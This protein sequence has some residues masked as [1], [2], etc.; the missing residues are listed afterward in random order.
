MKK[1]LNALA[2]LAAITSLG[3][4]GALP[5]GAAGRGLPPTLA[6][7]SAAQVASLSLANAKKWGSCT[8]VSRGTAVGFTFGS[9]TDSGSREAR[10][11]VIFNGYHGQVLFLSGALYM[12]ESAALLRVQFGKSDPRDAN[13]WILLPPGNKSYRSVSNGLLFSSMFTQVRPGGVLHESKVGTL[14]G[15]KVVAVTGQANPELGLMR[16]VETLFV[17]AASPYLPVKLIA[18]GRSQGVPTSLSV[19]FSHWG[20]HFRITAPRGALTL[21][22]N[23][24]P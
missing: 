5:A 23:A 17:A 11:T 15:V 16:G 1:A 21:S 9:S 8:Y 18:G 14:G 12:K 24:L 13:R 2:T 20:D 3:A 22:K 7:M 10:Q 4:S 19:S 6:S